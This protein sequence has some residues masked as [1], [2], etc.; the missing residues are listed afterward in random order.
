MTTAL[1]A[2]TL[3]VAVALLSA[4]CDNGPS[5]GASTP[6]TGPRAPGKRLKVATTTTMIGDVVRTIGGDRIE[7]EVIMPAGTDPH[8]FKPSTGDIGRLAAADLIFYNGLHLE[9]K[10]V[11]TFEQRL[12]GKAVPVAEK[13]IPT[14]KLIPW[15]EGETGAHDPHVWFDVTLWNRVAMHIAERLEIADPAAKGYYNHRHSQLSDRLEELDRYAREQLATVPKDRR[16]LVTSHDAY[17]Y[18]GRAY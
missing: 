14:D 10:M 2:S 11:E 12:K 18:F 8:T 5:S 17:G 7:L 1:K 16:V 13:A 3:L 9:G 6:T 4:G 15:Q